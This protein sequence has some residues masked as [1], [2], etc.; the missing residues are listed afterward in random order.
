M[1]AYYSESLQR[2][3]NRVILLGCAYLLLGVGA[4]AFASSVTFAAMITL[5][6]VVAVAGICEIAYGLAGR[7]NGQLWPHLAFG[8]LA[9]ICGALI[10]LNPL[11]NAIGFTLVAGFWFSANGLAKVVGSVVERSAGWGWYLANGAISI[12]LGIVV[13]GGFP[14]SAFWMIGTF[15][16]AD[17]IITG[18]T[19]IGLG[20]T[21]KRARRYLVDET[22]STLHPEPRAS[23]REREE[24]PFH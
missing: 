17:L 15:I 13:L 12:L 6:V 21:V 20:T 7:H 18:L 4:M 8:C 22:Y 5:G 1:N 19:Q 14:E 16:G 9:M 24:H 10:V 3:S 2:G 23:E 11:I